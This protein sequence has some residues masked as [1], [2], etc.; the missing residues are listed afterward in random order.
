MRHNAVLLAGEGVEVYLDGVRLD[1]CREAD[2]GAG[3]AEIYVI[4]PDEL[5]FW[6]QRAARTQSEFKPHELYPGSGVWVLRVYGRTEVRGRIGVHD[7][8]PYRGDPPL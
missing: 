5:E 8:R 4:E 1:R 7:D 3:E 6:R 2:T